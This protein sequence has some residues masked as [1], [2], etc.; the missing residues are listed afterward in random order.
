MVASRRSGRNALVTSWT[1]TFDYDWK[2]EIMII[3]RRE[4]EVAE[5]PHLNL[6]EGTFEEELGLQGFYGVVSH[7]YHKRAPTDWTEL[8]ASP[9]QWP[10]HEEAPAEFLKPQ[11]YSP[12]DFQGLSGDFFTGARELFWNE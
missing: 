5:R 4:G 11:C 10:D 1:Q 2:N 6:P 9:F 8:K 7:L 12:T 3:Y